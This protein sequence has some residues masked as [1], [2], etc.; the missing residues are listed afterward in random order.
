MYIVALKDET[1]VEVNAVYCDIGTYVTGKFYDE[2]GI[3]TEKSGRVI[4]ILDE[5][6]VWE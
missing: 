5:Y 4:H 3:E 2:N 6:E 1:I